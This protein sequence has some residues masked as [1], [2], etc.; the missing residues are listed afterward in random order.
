MRKYLSGMTI[1]FAAAFIAALLATPASAAQLRLSRVATPPAQ[2]PDVSDVRIG[3]PDVTETFRQD[4]GN[5]SLGAFSTSTSTIDDGML[6]ITVDEN[7]TLSWSLYDG[8]FADFYLEVDTAHLDG[9]LYNEHGVIFRLQDSENF[10]VFTISSVGYYHLCKYVDGAWEIIVPWTESDAIETGDGSENRVGLLAVG[11]W[12]VLLVN[13]EE[14]ERVRDDSFASGA[15]A[16]TAGSMDQPGPQIGFDNLRLWEA[17]TQAMPRPA[18][19]PTRTQR[20][21][22]TPTPRA[23]APPVSSEECLTAWVQV[24]NSM[25][26]S[27][28]ASYGGNANGGSGPYVAPGITPA[29][30][31]VLAQQISQLANAGCLLDVAANLASSFSNASNAAYRSCQ[32]MFPQN[33]DS[34]CLSKFSYDL[35]MARQTQAIQA[36]QT[37]RDQCN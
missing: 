13:K 12:I 33:W 2:G 32:A 6:T 1:A 19:T 3:A 30:C 20:I 29:A 22:P 15:L 35:R 34:M 23:S 25:V 37:W 14:L 16:L 27:G 24:A 17:T 7:N 9:P 10:Y 28:Y 18:A 5:W 11:D 4:N 36:A 8:T 21:A 26:S 31:N